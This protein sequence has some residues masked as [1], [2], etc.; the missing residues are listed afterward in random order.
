MANYLITGAHGFI[1]RH[2]ARRLG[3]AGHQVWGVGHGIWPASEASQWGVSAWVNGDV[4]PANLDLLTRE[5]GEPDTVFHLAGGSSVGAAVLNPREDFFRTVATTAELLEWM[6]HHAPRASLVAVSS[7]AV[8]GA[9]HEG[10]IAVNARRNPCSPYGYHKRMMEDLCSSFAAGYGM[11]IAVARLFS[12][13]GPGLRKQLLWDLCCKLDRGAKQLGLG[14]TG[15]ELRDWTHVEDVADALMVVG[16]YTSPEPFLCNVGTGSGTSV[17][18]VAEQ[19]LANWYGTDGTRPDLSFSGVSRP[20]DPA[21]LVAG[22]GSNGPAFTWRRD[23]RRALGD[24][25]RW[26]RGLRQES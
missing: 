10:P 26:Y 24:Y 13:Y 23:L 4:V 6:R 11:R 14:G 25:V 2:L 9:G 1:G 3:Q 8:Y 16:Q 15:R 18:E 12:V 17:A 7:A 21:S 19:I 20:G 22:V 5:Q